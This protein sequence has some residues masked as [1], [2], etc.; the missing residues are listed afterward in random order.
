M[1]AGSSAPV[2]SA[3]SG[4]GLVQGFGGLVIGHQDER[5]RALRQRL[6]E[7]GQVQRARRKGESGYAAAALSGLQVAAG[8]VERV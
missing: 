6:H 8:P 7:E 4:Q 1:L 2:R 3:G 5:G